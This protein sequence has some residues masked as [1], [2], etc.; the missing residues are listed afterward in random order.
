M[1]IKCFFTKILLLLAFFCLNASFLHA[2]AVPNS[3]AFDV[4]LATQKSGRLTGSKYVIVR[5]GSLA[6]ISK[7]SWTQSFSQVEFSFKVSK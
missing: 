1:K 4:V 7:R 6:E 3:I 2:N 5:I